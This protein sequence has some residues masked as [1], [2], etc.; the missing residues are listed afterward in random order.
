[1][2]NL[3]AGGKLDAEVSDPSHRSGVFLPSMSRCSEIQA[4]S[5]LVTRKRQTGWQTAQI[6]NSQQARLI[7]LFAE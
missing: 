3:L 4:E 7:G 6:A 5:R 1:M 2:L